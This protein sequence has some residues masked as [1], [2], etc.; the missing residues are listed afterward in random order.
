MVTDVLKTTNKNLKKSNPK[1]VKDVYEQNYLI[2]NFSSKMKILD[3]Q[4]KYFLKKN[5]Y[6]HPQVIINTNKGKKV[7]KDL[8]KYISKNPKKIY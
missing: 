8:F 4:I 6:N 7:I 5:M 3:N 2:V 1:T